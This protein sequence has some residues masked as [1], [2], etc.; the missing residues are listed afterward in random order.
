MM[1][2]MDTGAQDERALARELLRG[3]AGLGLER[4]D[5]GSCGTAGVFGLGRRD[6]CTVAVAANERILL[7]AVRRTHTQTAI[8]ASCFRCR[9]QRRQQ[10][11]RHASRLAQIP[12]RALPGGN[13]S[14]A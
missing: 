13:A 2:G 11:D 6:G 1:T 14:D 10:T 12:Q 4:P 3:R 8:L 7:A 9:E 5:S